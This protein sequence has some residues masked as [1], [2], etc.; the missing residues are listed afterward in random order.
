MARP[1]A[2]NRTI[3]RTRQG[4]RATNEAEGSHAEDVELFGFRVIQAT[5]NGFSFTISIT[6][7]RATQT[8]KLTLRERGNN[9]TEMEAELS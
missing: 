2:G 5:P 9:W 6:R 1:R 8:D 3:R 4:V 7:T